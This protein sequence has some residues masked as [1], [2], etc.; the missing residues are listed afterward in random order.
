MRL[1]RNAW[2]RQSSGYPDEVYTFDQL[3]A[4]PARLEPLLNMLA[5]GDAATRAGDAELDLSSVMK[6][7]QVISGEIVLEAL[8]TRTMRVMLENAGGQRGCFI[9]RD[10]GRL[11]VEGLCQVDDGDDTPPARRL[12]EHGQRRAHRGRVGVVALVDQCE[13]AIPDAKQQPL[14]APLDAAEFLKRERRQREVRADDMRGGQHGE[15][16]HRKMPPR[17][18][19][20]IA[21]G[22]A[23]DFR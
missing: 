2:N 8:W 7:S 1:F 23:E 3:T 12:A 17:R 21:H 18:A 16:I 11:V 5:P 15:R 4:D 10:D 9:V 13:I 6:A 14:A 20:A 22:N 19:D